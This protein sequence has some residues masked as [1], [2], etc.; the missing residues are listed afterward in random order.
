[1]SRPLNI[2]F[3]HSDQHRFD[4][5]GANGHSLVQTPHLDRL[6]SEG[7][8][9]THAF[10]PIPVCTPARNS[11]LF[12]LWP[13]QHLAIT[14][15][16]TEAPRPAREGLTSFSELLAKAGYQ[17][18]YVGKWGLNPHKNP[19]AYGF[20]EYVPESDYQ[21]WRTG[22]RL[23]PLPRTNGYF[24]ETDHAIRADQSRLAWG[25]DRV[26][27]QMARYAASDHPFFLRWDPS[28]PHL[29]NI[30]PEPYAS[31]YAPADIPPWIGFADPLQDKPYAQ[32]Q[33]QRTW[34][35][36]GWTWRDWAP[37]VGRYLG[38]ITLLDAQIGRLLGHLEALGLQ[39][40][41][42]VVYTADHGDMCGSHGMVDKHLVLYDDV[43]RVPLLVRSPGQTRTGA[44][45]AFVSSALDL[46]TTF[47]D[48]AAIPA[49][50]A[51]RGQ[52]LMPLLSG[53]DETER[54]FAF[55][56]YHGGQFGLYSQRMARDRRWKYIWNAT[57][58]DEL[59]DLV[60]DP[61]EIVNL[62]TASEAQTEMRRLRCRL[63]EWMEAE[64]DPLCN[65]W[66]KPRLLR[67]SDSEWV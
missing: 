25:A 20:R 40:Q 50:E 3:I 31:L 16:G 23:P 46:A 56:M 29:P 13:T 28:E 17:L 57:A 39:E 60:N 14:N 35:V 9:F 58:E 27:E 21:T 54:D 32:A 52:S 4:C 47:C 30:V 36:A 61:G 38:E 1:M 49:P 15:P 33:Q 51:F 62:V 65:E 24:G 48:L 5:L 63:V 22:Q 37:I 59:Y 19:T 66:T 26:I 42:V 34:G 8:N 11:L 7:T 45:D 41:T 18:S 10:C 44:C 6:A 67:Q 12:G 43:V 64:G 2:L 55:A 53:A